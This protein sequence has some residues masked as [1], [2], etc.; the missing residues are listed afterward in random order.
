MGDMFSESID[1]VS[2]DATSGHWLSRQRSPLYHRFRKRVGLALARLDNI[3]QV[4]PVESDLGA[5]DS[6]FFSA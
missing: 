5:E 4:R 3:F 2:T 1:V 6:I